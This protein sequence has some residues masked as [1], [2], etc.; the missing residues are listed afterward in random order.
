MLGTEI[1]RLIVIVDISL[2][3]FLVDGIALVSVEKSEG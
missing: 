3:I 1:M 2:V